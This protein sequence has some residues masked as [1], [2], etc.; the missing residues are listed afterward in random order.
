MH[1]GGTGAGGD[2]LPDCALQAKRKQRSLLRN[3]RNALFDAM[4]FVCRLELADCELEAI[5]GELARLHAAFEESLAECCG[6]NS[7]VLGVGSQVG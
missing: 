2:V 3:A 5:T 6:R 7:V 4:H 1:D